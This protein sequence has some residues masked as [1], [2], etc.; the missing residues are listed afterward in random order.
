[1]K[2]TSAVDKRIMTMSLLMVSNPVDKLN[3]VSAVTLPLS[4]LRLMSSCFF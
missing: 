4:K 3:R 1:M 2:K